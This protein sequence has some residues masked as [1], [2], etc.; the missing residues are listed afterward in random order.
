MS[1]DRKA[2][3]TSILDLS[4]FVDKAIRVK[5]SGGREVAGVLKGYDH[6][7]NIVLDNCTEFIRDPEDPYKLSDETRT[8]GIVVCRGTAVV[9]ICPVDGMEAIANPFLQQE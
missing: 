9:L 5:F 2:K 7:L 1:D 6:L 4:K 8:L 3:K